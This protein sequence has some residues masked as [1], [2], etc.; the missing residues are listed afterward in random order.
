MLFEGQNIGVWTIL[1]LY[2][3]GWEFVHS[4][5]EIIQNPH[6]LEDTSLHYGW[7]AMG[8]MTE[9]RKEEELECKSHQ[10]SNIWPSAAS[11]NE[12]RYLENIFLDFRSV[13][14]T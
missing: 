1:S 10:K 4:R 7:R 2:R 9:G 3:V 5:C 14:S 11:K 13:F 8:A 6:K 12:V